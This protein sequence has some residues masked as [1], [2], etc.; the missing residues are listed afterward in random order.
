MLKILSILL[1]CP[2]LVFSQDYF[3]NHFGGTAGLVLNFGT[4]INAIG[5]N[6]KGYYTDYFFQVN[7]NSTVYF[8]EKGLGQRTRFWESRNAVGL[9][10]LA[11]KRQMESD[12]QLDGL[13]H[14]TPYNYGLGFNYLMYFDN[15]GT[16]QYS[17]GFSAHIKNVSIYHENDVFGGRSKD[18]F[19]T[20]QFYITYRSGDFK[21]GIGISMWTGETAGA[22]W[23]RAP[24]D[25]A[26]N[27]FKIL[28]DLP[29]GRTSHGIL[30][31]SFMYNLGMGQTVHLKAGIDSENIRHAFQNRLI[32]DLIFLPKKIERKSP[33]YPRLDE[34]GS[35]AFT[36]EDV[37]RSKF[38]LQFGMNE[39]WSN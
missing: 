1:L 2:T 4:H 12:F 17:G 34:F 18:R 35:P 7:A 38:Y 28:E 29:Y 21:A 25:N 39:N 31:G 3:K 14:Q 27:G 37:R 16:S 10:L 36:D 33:H 19:R 8:Y 24:T 11:G 22:R 15:A 23:E 5:L 9:V 6:L 13:N 32:H 30:Y 20:G 26:P